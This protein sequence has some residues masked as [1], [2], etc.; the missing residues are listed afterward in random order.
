MDVPRE[1]V[2]V[3]EAIERFGI[4][5]TQLYNLIREGRIDAFKLGRRT[6]IRTDSV[7]AFLSSLPKTGGAR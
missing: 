4:A 1:N 2:T 6:L 3:A 5:R 7:R